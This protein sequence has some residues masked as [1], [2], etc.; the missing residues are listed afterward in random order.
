MTSPPS[1]FICT[2]IKLRRTHLRIAISYGDVETVSDDMPYIEPNHFSDRLIYAR[3]SRYLENHLVSSSQA[4][5]NNFS[6]HFSITTLCPSQKV[7]TP[8]RN[9]LPHPNLVGRREQCPVFYLFKRRKIM[10]L[11]QNPFFGCT[12]LSSSLWLRV[13]RCHIFDF[14]IR[15]MTFPSPLS[16]TSPAVQAVKS[17][18]GTIQS[19]RSSVRT[20]AISMT[21]I[22]TESYRS[23]NTFSMICP[24]ALEI[25][26]NHRRAPKLPRC[27]AKIS[28]SLWC[29][30]PQLNCRCRQTEN[31]P[32]IVCN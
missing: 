5:S 3:R 31:V 15:V 30:W 23:R 20:L 17:K 19:S 14:D 6:S 29:N 22:D 21:P 7:G 12:A 9:T 27:G 2:R 4:K 25:S 28:R 8:T 11:L 16:T 18:T 24:L 26:V 10:Q 1:Y 32:S 13:G